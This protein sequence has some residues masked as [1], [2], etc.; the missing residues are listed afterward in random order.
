MKNFSKRFCMGRLVLLPL[1]LAMILSGCQ[2]VQEKLEDLFG[3]SGSSSQGTPLGKEYDG[4][5]G[6]AITLQP[7]PV[8]KS[9]EK[10]YSYRTDVADKAMS[11]FIKRREVDSLRDTNPSGWLRTVVEEINR[12]AKNDFEKARLAHDVV[13]V[14]IS[15]D[16]ASYWSGSLPPQDFASVIKSCKAVCE[17][18]A[19][20]YQR[21][22]DSLKL[23]C[24]TIHGYARG[25]GTSLAN[26][27]KV[28]ESNHAWNRVQLEGDWYLVDCTWDAGHMEGKTARQSYNTDWLFLRPEHFIY[29]H[30]PQ[31]Q[32]DQLLATP[33]S[34]Q[35]FAKLPDLRPKFFQV[36]K[37]FAPLPAKTNQA[38]GALAMEFRE[39][40]GFQL[41]FTL[42]SL[43]SGRPASNSLMV[44]RQPGGLTKAE[45][46]F[47]SAGLYVVDVFWRKV[48]GRQG[49]S[50]GQFLVES[51]QA[52]G[53]QYPA[54]FPVDGVEVQ[55]PLTMP[56]SAGTTVQFKVAAPQKK[57]VAVIYGSTYIQLE[58][59]GRGNFSG[60][61]SVP[62]TARDISI[63][64]ANSQRGSYQIVAKYSVK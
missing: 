26:E 7:L 28:T 51:S 34:P 8:P 40:A 16:A 43:D 24:K 61:V 58:S 30:L 14:L 12:V 4:Q 59:D 10:A 41:D 37:D 21:L 55:S 63:G 45:F 5:R 49:T 52:G 15:Y 29:S 50:C 22:C 53:V 23:P 1:A 18:Y 44:R 2:S 11:A 33:L 6:T 54:L 35:D 17:G 56:L 42:R 19:A 38:D 64:V 13:A 31:R 25:V 9:Y 46:S 60:Q 62:H 36:A 32:Q 57:F 27:T 20:V 39:R 47:P 3:S 48:G